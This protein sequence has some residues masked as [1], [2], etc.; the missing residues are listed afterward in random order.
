[1][2]IMLSLRLEFKQ[3]QQSRWFENETEYGCHQNM[4]YASFSMF[5]I[6]S[7]VLLLKFISASSYR[8]MLA[9]F[10]SVDMYVRHWNKQ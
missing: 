4:D 6:V 5:I 8:S 7:L 9:S 3:P 10:V 1:M 2:S